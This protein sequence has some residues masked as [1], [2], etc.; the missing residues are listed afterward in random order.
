[1]Y[2]EQ[3]KAAS[4]SIPSDNISLSTTSGQISGIPSGFKSP[5]R[6]IVYPNAQKCVGPRPTNEEW[7]L[8]VARFVACSSKIFHAQATRF[9]APNPTTL[10]P[11]STPPYQPTPSQPSNDPPATFTPE[12]TLEN[13]NYATFDNS[14][15]YF[16]DNGQSSQSSQTSFCATNEL[17]ARD[18]STHYPGSQFGDALH[19]H[20]PPRV[21]PPA[22]GQGHP[23][24]A[25]PQSLGTI[26]QLFEKNSFYV[27]E[28]YAVQASPLTATHTGYHAHHPTQIQ[29]MNYYSPTIESTTGIPLH[30]INSIIV[31]ALPTHFEYIPF[32]WIPFHTPDVFN[33]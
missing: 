27:N 12:F 11:A 3:D 15:F 33:I 23:V 16:I 20:V 32:F 10:V 29:K 17:A 13:T 2:Y 19:H 26:G 8:M 22:L 31:P 5:L 6:G 18:A 9:N 28:P 30:Q 1:M 24:E 7:Q 14:A 4:Y 21:V 25:L